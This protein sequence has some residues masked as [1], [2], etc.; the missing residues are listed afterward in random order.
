MGSGLGQGHTFSGD[1]DIQLFDEQVVKQYGLSGLRLGDLVAIEDADHTFGRIFRTGAV[2]IGVVVHSCCTTAGH[3]PG[4]TSL[5]SSRDG[6]IEPVID[7]S[8]NIANYF[9][10]GRA[11]P[12]PER[13]RRAGARRRTQADE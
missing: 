13:R 11:R 6:K 12:R 2:S 9:R 4:V 7:A 10:I 3:G 8:A 1:Y 5:M